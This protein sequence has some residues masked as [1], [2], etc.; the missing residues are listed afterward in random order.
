MLKKSANF[1]LASL[2]GSTYRNVRLAS[3]LAAVALDGHFEHPA[4]TAEKLLTKE[5]CWH[6]IQPQF[7]KA[8]SVQHPTKSEG[9]LFLCVEPDQSI[10]KFL[11]KILDGNLFGLIYGIYIF[12][13]ERRPYPLRYSL[14]FLC[15]V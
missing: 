1:V 7:Q 10:C 5:P 15:R 8:L 12:Y 9:S 13:D 3:S 11:S 14:S 6:H 2:R 4:S